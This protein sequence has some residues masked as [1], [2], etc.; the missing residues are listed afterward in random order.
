MRE[1]CGIFFYFFLLIHINLT[2]FEEKNKE[3]PYT[4]SV[5]NTLCTDDDHLFK[6]VVCVVK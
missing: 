6:C 4:S 2:A 5:P 3:Y 1:L